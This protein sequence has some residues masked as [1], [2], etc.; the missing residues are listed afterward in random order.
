VIASEGSDIELMQRNPYTRGT[1]T[2]PIC[3]FS[4]NPDGKRIIEYF[5]AS[6][7][8]ERA[9]YIPNP[10]IEFGSDGAESIAISK[11]LRQSIVKR[12]SGLVLQSRGE[13]QLA[14]VYLS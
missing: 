13:I 3:V 5:G 4:F 12:A 2:K 14:S 7:K 6:D 11:L 8:V 1:K 9:L 10:S